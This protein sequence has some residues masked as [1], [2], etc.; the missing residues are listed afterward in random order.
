[1]PQQ[2]P[3]RSAYATGNQQNIASTTAAAAAVTT[4]TI[5]NNSN[6]NTSNNN[7][8]Q[9]IQ[10][11]NQQQQQQY[12]PTSLVV[13]QKLIKQQQQVV[14]SITAS[15]ESK[16]N[17][18][19]TTKNACN[20]NG[21]ANNT[22]GQASDNSSCKTNTSLANLAAG[23]QKANGLKNRIMQRPPPLIL[24][25]VSNFYDNNQSLVAVQIT[26]VNNEQ[27]KN[28]TSTLS[29]PQQKH[30]QISE[31]TN[32]LN[33]SS[34]TIPKPNTSSTSQNRPISTNQKFWASL[35]KNASKSNNQI[36]QYKSGNVGMN[37]ADSTYSQACQLPAK[38]ELDPC[39]NLGA[40]LI[41]NHRNTTSIQSKFQANY[42]A[43]SDVKTTTAPSVS[44][45]YVSNNSFNKHQNN[46]SNLKMNTEYGRISD[47]VRHQQ[48]TS[49]LDSPCLT[50]SRGNESDS[51]K[52]Q[53]VSNTSEPDDSSAHGNIAGS[54]SGGG[55]LIGVDDPT[56]PAP[57][58]PISVDSD[59]AAEPQ[60]FSNRPR[61]NNPFLA[62][63]E[64]EPNISNIDTQGSNF[65]R[66]PA[67]FIAA[68][69]S[70]AINQKQNSAVNYNVNVTKEQTKFHQHF[71]SMNIN[72]NSLKEH[73]DWPQINVGI[74]SEA[75]G[76]MM[77]NQVGSETKHQKS[78]I[79]QADQIDNGISNRSQTN[80]PLSSR[81]D[82]VEQNPNHSFHQYYD[83][84][85]QPQQ[86]LYDIYSNKSL[87]NLTTCEPTISLD[88]E[89]AVCKPP[90]SAT[91]QLPHW[92]E[93]TYELNNAILE[94]SSI[95]GGAENG[96]FIYIVESGDIILELDQI[97]VSGFT[98]L[99]F[100]D[101]I[102]SNTTHLLS[103]VQTKHSHSLTINLK[104]YL[105][106]S[107]AKDSADKELQDLIRENIYRRTIP[108]TTRPPREDEL[109]K[110]DYHFLTKEQFVELDNRGQLLECG[111]YNGHYY[112]TLRPFSDL[113]HLENS[114]LNNRTNLAQ[115]QNISQDIHESDG[116]ASIGSL[117]LNDSSSQVPMKVGENPLYEN[118][119]TLTKQQTQSNYV[120]NPP[121]SFDDPSSLMESN[122]DHLNRAKHSTIGNLNS[123]ALPPGWERVY[124]QTHG[125]YYIDHNTMRTQYEQPYET[126]LTKGYMGF[127]FTLVE[128]DNGLLLVRSIIPGGPAHMNGQIRPGDILMSAVGIS[129][130]GLQ[131]TD[132]ARL[133]STFAVGDRIKLTF[134]RGNHAVDSNLVPDEYL[135]SHGSTCDVNSA[136]ELDNYM[137]YLQQKVAALE[138]N[139]SSTIDDQDF[140]YHTIELKRGEQ[141]FG[142]TISDS[143]GVQRVKN[144]QD[145]TICSNLKQ[146]DLLL[147]LNGLDISNLKHK[148]L[149]ERL[150]NILPGQ[151]AVLVVKR[152][153]RFRSKTPMTMHS[154]NYHDGMNNIRQR[155]CKTPAVDPLSRHRR[156]SGVLTDTSISQ[157]TF[158]INPPA[159][160]VILNERGHPSNIQMQADF[161]HRGDN[162][163]IYDT[164]P[165]NSNGLHYYSQNLQNASGP[166]GLDSTMSISQR[167]RLPLMGPSPNDN[168]SE[169]SSSMAY[170]YQDGS[171][172]IKN[173][174]DYN[175]QPRMMQ[176]SN[177]QQQYSQ[178]AA[179]SM[180]GT[181]SDYYPVPL[182][183]NSDMLKAESSVIPVPPKPIMT[184]VVDPDCAPNCANNFYANN[185]E[186]ALQRVQYN[187]Q[188]MQ[189][190]YPQ[191]NQ[192]PPISS[193]YLS[194][195]KLLA[196]NEQQQQQ[197][198]NGQAEAQ[199]N[200]N[201][202][203]YHQVDLDRG[204][205]YSNWGI[206]LIGGAEVDRAIS[207]GSIVSGGAAAKN[208]KLEPGDE[209]ISIDG[210]DVVGATHQ[211]VVDLISAC[212]QR[213]SLLIRRKKFAE[214]C[215]VALNRNTDEGFGFYI[216]SK[217]NGPLIGNIIPGSLA[218]RCQQL[219]ENDRIVA[220][221]GSEITPNTQHPEIVN[222]IK[223]SGS[224]LRLRIV[225]AN[226][227][228]V[229]LIKS[230]P[231][232][233]FGFRMRGGSEYGTPLFILR[234]APNG[235]ARDLLNVGDQIVEING[236]PTVGM[237][238]Q[239]AANIIKF[240]DPIVK[241]KLRRSHTT[242]RSLLVD[243]PRALQNFNQVITVTGESQI[244]GD[245]K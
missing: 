69:G 144:V 222:M 26:N 91:M 55:N 49:Q 143:S 137:A 27:D 114:K 220:V 213:A 86:S 214:A 85:Q 74:G 142:F 121:N 34:N 127:G 172:Q 4:T 17:N 168:Q 239:Q 18:G 75:N 208:G 104:D 103:A 10:P 226:C 102:E 125:T 174:Y 95:A 40:D 47:D 234:V 9:Q 230:S 155:N 8:E 153:R 165:P 173:H 232:D 207:I 146:G 16:Y 73:N 87:T 65:H 35:N 185:E 58:H 199:G 136:K 62:M 108:C 70:T 83:I 56:P 15:N 135:F 157:T 211:H 115:A 130:A 191:Q 32:S 167:K 240:S 112:G 30:N 132:I 60:S 184:Y 31:I 170:G 205:K 202:Y 24:D 228:S 33:Y 99:E 13:D 98:L 84:H 19:G 131:H 227:Y 36:G 96:Q 148:E 124:D 79:A 44:A 243:S 198:H 77:T 90:P 139:N 225:P 182:Y 61:E 3:I 22:N 105:N 183:S 57:T 72:D 117:V 244:K 118:H 156:S 164:N 231:N 235:L 186:I 51:G 48:Y 162:Q 201:Q 149:V 107:F 111:V 88:S 5:I 163:P 23:N 53:F 237:T 177:Q 82:R 64:E 113:S 28:A 190:Q 11:T 158:P 52:A 42:E 94:V 217:G 242:P 78:E 6:S 63:D 1:M 241:L 89:S 37:S 175:D 194:P 203:E 46:K 161:I 215:D 123:E 223:E 229:E 171:R 180:Y 233:N 179:D 160:H 181:A 119:D 221:N 110:I 129:V 59:M 219:H 45:N 210:V 204:D 224:T 50:D 206:R 200:P 39:S 187:Q 189:S 195:N 54:E 188:F 29:S 151:D 66:R 93:A 176:H 166:Q 236:I 209:I 145:T 25:R 245:V 193:D 150:K 192:A 218:D 197:H 43:S 120:I 128:A 133:F 141:G 138:Q 216:I 80:V 196:A 21:H 97:K 134:A 212:S 147:Q 41:I 169:Q 7:N 116:H 76:S 101:L 2:V 71:E 92:T 238:H 81:I 178:L 106:S 68:T 140:E 152:R 126:E 67:S 14:S 38:E 122:S 154:E 20:N 159:S 12:A 100:N 109:D